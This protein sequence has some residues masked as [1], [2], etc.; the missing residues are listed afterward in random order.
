MTIASFSKFRK[1]IQGK[2]GRAARM[3]RDF[4]IHASTI[5][6]W[7]RDK[8]IPWFRQALVLIYIEKQLKKEA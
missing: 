5:A 6:H 2:R 1:F 8:E 3:A 4:D 7:L